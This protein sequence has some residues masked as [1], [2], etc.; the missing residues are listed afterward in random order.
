ML[1]REWTKSDPA[2]R[3]SQRWQT[4]LYEYIPGV[5]AKESVDVIETKDQKVERKR[6]IGLFVSIEE[7]HT[8]GDLFPANRRFSP[9]CV[10][11]SD[12]VVSTLCAETMDFRYEDSDNNVESGVGSFVALYD[13]V[14]AG[15]FVRQPFRGVNISSCKN[16]LFIFQGADL[17]KVERAMKAELKKVF[18]K[19]DLQIHDRVVSLIWVDS[20]VL[21]CREEGPPQKF[22]LEGLSLNDDEVSSSEESDGTIDY[23]P[24]KRADNKRSFEG[25]AGSATAKRAKLD[26]ED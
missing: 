18:G 8:L 6:K 10:A 23:I 22:V 26:K 9:S 2:L 16:V 24:L 19:E 12:A 5:K 11:D 4:W 20:F 1:P 25:D 17:V 14:F 13:A 3:L 7:P 15:A 21:Q